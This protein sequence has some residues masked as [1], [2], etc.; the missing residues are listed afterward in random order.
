MYIEFFFIN[1]II[2]IY[3]MK[4]INDYIDI[5]TNIIDKIKDN[6]TNIKKIIDILDNIDT[7]N[8]N[9]YTNLVKEVNN[10]YVIINEEINKSI[11]PEFKYINTEIMN[12]KNKI[13]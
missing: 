1:L 4:I 7:K 10:K 8:K 3:I 5:F 12:I 11:Y 9:D 6:Q 13:F 2:I